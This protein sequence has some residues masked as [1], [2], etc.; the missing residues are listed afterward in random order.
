MLAI[1]ILSVAAVEWANE[2][3]SERERYC[4]TEYMCVWPKT[5]LY[6]II[7]GRFYKLSPLVS[8]QSSFFK[9]KLLGEK[10][11]EKC[12]DLKSCIAATHHV[13]PWLIEN[14]TKENSL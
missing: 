9:L 4:A 1:R 10:I 12:S 2:W 5:S 11:F 14:Y 13:E 6:T 3:V 8:P 7:I